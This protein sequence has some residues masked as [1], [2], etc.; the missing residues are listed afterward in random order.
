MREERSE[1]STEE[2]EKQD[3]RELPD[4]EEMSVIRGD[5]IIAPVPVVPLEP[6]STD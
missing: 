4:R 2:L 6:P 3:A 1:L 5:P